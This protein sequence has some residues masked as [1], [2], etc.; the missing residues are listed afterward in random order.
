MNVSVHNRLGPVIFRDE[1]ALAEEMLPITSDGILTNDY[2]FG[3][4]EG[5][6]TWEIP[7]GWNA[8]GTTK[9]TEP[10]GT[11]EGSTQEFY[12]SQ[13]GFVGVR[14][15]RNQATRYVN[16]ARYLNWKRIYNNEVRRP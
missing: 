11:F 10:Y 14:K 2:S 12:I 13:W 16:D 7:F 5:T 15:F 9:G 6:M 8:K 3:W 1:A 4:M